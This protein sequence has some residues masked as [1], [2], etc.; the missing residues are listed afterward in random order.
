MIRNWFGAALLTA[1]PLMTFVGCHSYHVDTTIENHTGAAVKLI[2]VDYP[3]AS[4][5]T[6]VIAAGSDFHYRFQVQGSGPI[7]VQYTKP[8][9]HTAQATG[10]TLAEGQEGG[11]QIILLPES[12]IEFEPQLKPSH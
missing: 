4:F 10:P 1:A 8:D 9:G 3:N 5:G 2:E 7:K 6:E 12:K 11:L